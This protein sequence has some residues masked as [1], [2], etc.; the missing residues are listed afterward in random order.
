LSRSNSKSVSH[1]SFNLRAGQLLLSHFSNA[2]STK[3]Y[4]KTIIKYLQLAKIE[5]GLSDKGFRDVRMERSP[6]RELETSSDSVG[7]TPLYLSALIAYFLHLIKLFC[8][9]FFLIKRYEHPFL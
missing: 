7:I 8:I 5:A 3:R 2:S 4:R 1:A 9:L 6:A